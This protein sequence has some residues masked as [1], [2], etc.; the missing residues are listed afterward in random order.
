M[1]CNVGGVAAAADT[2]FSLVCVLAWTL[3]KTMGLMS[4]HGS[5]SGI[6]TV[7]YLTGHGMWQHGAVMA[8]RNVWRDLTPLLLPRTIPFP[9]LFIMGKLFMCIA[10]LSG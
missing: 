8:W 5:G 10:H 3:V 2:P 9:F 6:P 1:S 4:R 7:L